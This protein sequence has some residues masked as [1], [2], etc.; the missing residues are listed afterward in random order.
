MVRLTIIRLILDLAALFH[1]CA[2]LLEKVA[3]LVKDDLKYWQYR[4]SW[5][6]WVNWNLPTLSAFIALFSE[7]MAKQIMVDEYCDYWHT[8]QDERQ[9]L[10]DAA[11]DAGE[12]W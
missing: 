6:A 10:V 4:G 11:E 3:I 12:Y 7:A 2:A 5:L 8:H 9:A 1:I